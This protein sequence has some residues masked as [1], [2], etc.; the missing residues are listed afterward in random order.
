MTQSEY[1]Q[2]AFQHTRI[3]S[4]SPIMLAGDRSTTIVASRGRLRRVCPDGLLRVRVHC[5]LARLKESYYHQ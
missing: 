5:L 4:E 2:A 1:T 3:E